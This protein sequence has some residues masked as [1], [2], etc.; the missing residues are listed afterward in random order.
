MQIFIKVLLDKTI[1]LDVEPNDTIKLVKQKIKDTGYGTDIPFYKFILIFS[2]KKLEDIKTLANYNI[3]D[4][5]NLN[6][7]FDQFYLYIIYNKG[8]KI[9][10]DCGLTFCT[11]CYYTL[12]LKEEIKKR[13]NIDTK[14]Q[15]LSVNGK[16]MKDN[17]SLGSNKITKGKEIKLN[18]INT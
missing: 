7:I 16:I 4:G 13:L 9:K 11:C 18:I 8:E 6:L 12:W 3:Q 14:N 1:S 5:S 15:E 2:G 10:I 17:E